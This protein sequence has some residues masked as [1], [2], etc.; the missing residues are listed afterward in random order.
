V[1]DDERCRIRMA[2]VKDVSAH[3]DPV[4]RFVVSMW[5]VRNDLEYVAGL[6]GS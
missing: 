5:A 4:A 1:D 6:V 3:D 2:Q